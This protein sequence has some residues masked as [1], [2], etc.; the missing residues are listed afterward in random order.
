[1]RYVTSIL[2]MLGVLLLT[3]FGGHPSLAQDSTKILPANPFQRTRP[4]NARAG[5]SKELQDAWERATPEQRAKAEQMFHDMLTKAKQKA[6][7]KG[8]RD[9]A[10]TTRMMVPFTDKNGKQH[11]RAATVSD[12]SLTQTGVPLPPPFDLKQHT[13]RAVGRGA[14]E[15]SHARSAP[16]AKFTAPSS[17]AMQESCYKSIEQFIRDTYQNIVLR[18]PYADE[19]SYWNNLLTQAQAQGTS[20]LFIQAQDVGRTLF[21]SQEYYNRFRGDRDYVYDL[22]RGFLHRDPEPYGWDAWFNL[23]PSIGR[24]AVL[25]GFTYSPEFNN[26]ASTLCNAATYDADADGLPNDFE[27]RVADAFT[28]FYHV[29]TGEP[30]NFAT[31]ADSTQLAVSQRFN[32]YFPPSPVSNFRVTPYNIGYLNGQLTGVLRV[33]YLTFWD[34]DSGLAGGGSCYAAPF[35]LE[36]VLS[37]LYAH[38]NDYERSAVL[39]AAPAVNNTF[40]FDPNAYS[41]YYMYTAAHEFTF[42]EQIAYLDFS[43]SPAPAGFHQGLALTRS[44]HGTYPFDPDYLALIPWW[45]ISDVYWQ[46]ESYCNCYF[47]PYCYDDFNRIIYCNLLYFT[48]ERFFF[49]CVVE[50]WEDAGGRLAGL[51]SNVGELNNPINRSHFIQSPEISTQLTTPFFR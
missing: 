31:F 29:S 12:K 27:N 5:S 44:K 34:R 11:M 2:L 46:I 7:R 4:A 41:L 33:D 37:G 24:D 30:D 3:T 43:A 48:A 10:R 6:G 32:P 21:H 22:Y 9:E 13:G 28:P 20:Q 50:R 35:G 8:G 18:Q 1:M 39:I 42:T 15:F 19:F 40:N 25:E 36:F 45:I 17:P 47:D 16:K 23:L 38:D 51:R 14:A 49:S 26:H